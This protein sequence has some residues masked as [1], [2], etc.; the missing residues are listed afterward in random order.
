MT[1]LGFGAPVGVDPANRLRYLPSNYVRAYQRAERPP[2]NLTLKRSR[3]PSVRMR[4]PAPAMAL[5]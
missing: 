5:K 2:E 4:L 3:D 1:K